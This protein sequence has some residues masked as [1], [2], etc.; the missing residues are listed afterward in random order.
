MRQRANLSVFWTGGWAC[1]R[2]SAKITCVCELWPKTLTFFSVFW[3][4]CKN[5]CKKKGFQAQ[6]QADKIYEI[7]RNC[8]RNCEFLM[9]FGQRCTKMSVFWGFLVKFTRI[10]AEKQCSWWKNVWACELDRI[11]D[12]EL[13][14]DEY[15]RALVF[16]FRFTNRKLA[17]K[18]QVRQHPPC[19]NGPQSLTSPP[20][21]RLPLIRSSTAYSK[22]VF[23]ALTSV[24]QKI[25]LFGF[26]S[27]ARRRVSPLVAHT[28]SVLHWKSAPGL[29]CHAHP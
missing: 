7:R 20:F 26:N 3:F 6:E 25:S 13:A 27:C 4:K 10:V 5:G 18:F 9:V 21:V 22:W 15:I 1:C 12:I 11:E 24:S 8:S 23:A 17:K 16:Q 2:L 19:S 29:A 14:S 28:P